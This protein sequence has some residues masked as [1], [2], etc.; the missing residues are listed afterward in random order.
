[1]TV[2]RSAHDIA[3]GT[4]TLGLSNVHVLFGKRIVLVD[5]GSPYEI[6]DLEAGLRE[7]G[8]RFS[9]VKCA[10]ITHV[11]ADHAGGARELQKR[12]IY[13]VA[14][15]ADRE[16]AER[17]DHGELHPTSWFA[18]Y[19]LQPL[20]PSRFDRFTPDISVTDRFDLRR[21][22]VDG[23]VIAT[24]GHTAGS[25]VVITGGGKVAL[26]G[27]LFRGGTWAGYAH[28][29]QPVEHFYQDNL[30]QAHE[31]IRMLLR[32]GIELFVMGHG[33]PSKAADVARVFGH[34]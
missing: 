1:M 19:M 9:D 11:H 4:V 33:G 2:P 27:D 30:K 25:L 26:V 31:Q 34:D 10:V 6:D 20:I 15:A 32:R 28:R 8:V 7:L 18:H 3:I 22:G 5:S 14:G 29:E 13:I 16:R 17:G 23:E 24:P 21:C 12:G